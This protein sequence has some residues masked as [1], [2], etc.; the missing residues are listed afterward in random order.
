MGWGSIK[1]QGRRWLMYIPKLQ[2]DDPYAGHSR[3]AVS[4]YLQ[5]SC[6]TL[7]LVHAVMRKSQSIA[8]LS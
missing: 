2:K 1:T 8:G 4:Q 5:P 3:L 6:L 7:K